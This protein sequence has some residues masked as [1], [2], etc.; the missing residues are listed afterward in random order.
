MN[1]SKEIDQPDR[2]AKLEKELEIIGGVSIAL[3]YLFSEHMRKSGIS[4]QEIIDMIDTLDAEYAV[5]LEGTNWRRGITAALNEMEK[6]L[7][8][9]SMN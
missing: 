3:L 9:P 4:H 6:I 8:Y 2:I 5:N 7:N 1:T